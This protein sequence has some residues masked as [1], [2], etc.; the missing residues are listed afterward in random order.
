MLT[1]HRHIDPALPLVICGFSK[2]CTVLNQLCVELP[3]LIKLISNEDSL[4]EMRS[5]LKHLIWLDGG[6][7]GNSN[8]WIVDEAVIDAV[9]RLG[10]VCYVYVTPYQIRSHKTWAIDEH[11]KF[12]ALLDKFGVE[13]RRIYYFKENEDD[14]DIHTHFGIIKEFDTNLII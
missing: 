13:S 1:G 8:S 4:V 3:E 14:F 11:E 5:R 6:H 7:S 12:C 10:C 9:K 2:G